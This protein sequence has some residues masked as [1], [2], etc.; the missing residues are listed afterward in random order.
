MPAIEGLGT[1]LCYDEFIA[2]H[3]AE[4]AW[5]EIDERTAAALCYTSGTTGNPKGALY[6]HRS[7]VLCALTAAL[8]GTLSL[9]PR[10]AV[11]PVVPMFHINAW[12]IPYAATLGG[13]K[14]VLPGP[15]LGRSRLV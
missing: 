11:L 4:F 12:C 14:L 6:S 8:P 13:S 9:S 2:P 15:R 1:L 7:L 10:D 3:P 5:P